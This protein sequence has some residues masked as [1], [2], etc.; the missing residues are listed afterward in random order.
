MRCAKCQAEAPEGAKFCPKCG[1]AMDGA[2]DELG[3]TRPEKI[4]AALEASARGPDAEELLWEGRFSKLAMIGAWVVAALVTIAAIVAGFV[5]G[6][7]TRGWLI[8]LGVL[9]AIWIL[10]LLRLVYQQ[11]SIKYTLTN[12]R[13]IHERGI[14]WRAVDR[15]EAID[16]DDVTFRQGP[17]ERMLGVGTVDVVSSDVSTPKFALVGIEDVRTVATLIDDTRRKERRKRGLHIETM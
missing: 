7:Q 5:A 15:I 9:A 16:I 14:L 13:L 6:F 4:T 2:A 1:A 17:V 11:M 3:R 12:Q 10:L 8:T